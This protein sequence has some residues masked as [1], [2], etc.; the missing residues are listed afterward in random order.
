MSVSCCFSK[1]K[2]PFTQM[3]QFKFDH[4]VTFTNVNY[5]FSI[6]L[7]FP[8]LHIISFK[9]HICIALAPMWKQKCNF[10]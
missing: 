10:K 3:L 2:P 7:H 9:L 8:P 1:P 4:N 6:Y 5:I